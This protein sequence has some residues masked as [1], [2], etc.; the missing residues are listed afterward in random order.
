MTG[1]PN[2]APIFHIS[3]VSDAPLSEDFDGCMVF[4]NTRHLI[5]LE[6]P[7]LISPRVTPPGQFLHTVFGAPT[8]AA[9]ADHQDGT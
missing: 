1:A 8:D 9:H 3:F 6:I 4:G 7:S 5:Y 2:E